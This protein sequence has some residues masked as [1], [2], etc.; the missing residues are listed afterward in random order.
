VARGP[1]SGSSTPDDRADQR[2]AGPDADLVDP[3]RIASEGLEE[4]EETQRHGPVPEL[5]DESRTAPDPLAV[6]SLAIDRGETPDVEA[7]QPPRHGLLGRLTSRGRWPTGRARFD[8]TGNGPITGAGTDSHTHGAQDAEPSDEPRVTT[9][10]EDLA[11]Q[12]ATGEWPAVS[13]VDDAHE[14]GED[15]A[16][17]TLL[18]APGQVL[19]SGA[20]D[21]EQQRSAAQAVERERV[22]ALL[23]EQSW[24]AAEAAEAEHIEAERNSAQRAEDARLE[25]LRLGATDSEEQRLAAERAEADRIETERAAAQQAEDDRLEQHRVAELQRD[26]GRAARDQLEDQRLERERAEHE[27]LAAERAAAERAEAERLAVLE[28]QR[29]SELREHDR[30]IAAQHLQA[31]ERPAATSAP[32][33]SPPAPTTRP[34]SS[35]AKG[36]TGEPIPRFVEFRPGSVLRYLFGALFVVFA[37]AAVIAIFRAVS[38]GSS[39]VVLAAVGLTGLAMVAWWALLSWAPPVVSVSNGLLEVSRGATSTSWDLRDPTT[40]ITF[41]GRPTSRS[42]KAVLR[43]QGGRPVTISAREVDA[44]QFVEIVGHYQSA[45]PE[46]EA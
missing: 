11:E 20:D 26:E 23:A 33:A 17:E 1:A 10:A 34:T 13:S 12:T 27:R 43:S 41:R 22:V 40:E 14:A 31:D 25:G 35:T 28:E 24:F 38:G 45:G 32:T 7:E 2:A 37:V 15:A 30:V 16:E 39:A 21:A 6:L 9:W 29:Q 44:A 18:D 19:D 46:V 4:V 8:A 42:W 5:V 36:G 3:L